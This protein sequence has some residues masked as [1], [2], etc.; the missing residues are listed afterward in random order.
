MDII[1]TE[2]DGPVHHR[3]RYLRG[4]LLRNFHRISILK[5]VAA[6]PRGSLWLHGLSHDWRVPFR[7]AIQ[8]EMERFSGALAFFQND[9]LLDFYLE[10]IPG[11]LQDRAVVFLRNVWPSDNNLVAPAIR[12]RTG[13]INPFLKPLSA[14][15]GKP[16]VQRSKHAFFYGHATGGAR[17]TRIDAIRRLKDAG[18]PLR[19]GLA[20]S[21]YTV[22]PPPDLCVDPIPSARYARFLADSAICLALHG[23]CPLTYRLFEGLSRRCLV[24]AQDLGSIRFAD[25]GLKPGVHYVSAKEDLS[26]LVDLVRYHLDHLEEAQ[27]IADAGVLHFQKYFQ[28]SGVNLPQPLY[29][30]MIGSWSNMELPRGRSTAKGIV[31]KLLLPLIHSL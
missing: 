29:R 16:L 31:I 20:E 7:A 9:D 21:Q 27:A 17:H 4:G 13:Y 25:C 28:F 10:K 2:D 15:S 22:A 6:S 24:I 8:H 26:D 23:N 1:F 18:V 14:R 30:E 3:S 5:D 12:D 11:P 19:G